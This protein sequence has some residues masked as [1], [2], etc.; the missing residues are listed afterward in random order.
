[1]SEVYPPS[2]DSYLLAKHISRDLKG[3]NVL[4]IGCGSGIL[5]VTAAINGAEVLAIDINKGALKSTQIMAERFGVKVETLG[6]DLFQN[7]KGK[8]DLILFNPPYVPAD[9]MDKYLT[10][11]MKMATTSGNMGVDLVN[12]FLKEFKQHL[13]QHGKVL[14]II[15][16]LNQIKDE[17]EKS[18]WKEIDSTSFFFEKIYLMEYTT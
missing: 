9:E 7:V 15:S 8:F 4:D 3:K 2:E 5:S 1:M 17:L 11:E 13:N 6:S 18:G 12:R 14:M 10:K 16:S